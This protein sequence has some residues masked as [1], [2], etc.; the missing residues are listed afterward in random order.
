M[1]VMRNENESTINVLETVAIIGDSA[2]SGLTRYNLGV[3]R[4]RISHPGDLRLPA[5]LAQPG[6]MEGSDPSTANDS[7]PVRRH[8]R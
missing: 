2:D 6:N 3:V 8:S 7:D 4:V 5:Q 1:Q